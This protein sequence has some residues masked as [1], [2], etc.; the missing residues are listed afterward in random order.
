MLS[1][2]QLKKI[3]ETNRVNLNVNPGI[4]PILLT[5]EGKTIGSLQNFIGITGLPKTGKGKFICGMIASGLS[6]KEVFGMRLKLIEGRPR[7]GFITTD[8]GPHELFNTGQ[9]IKKK[10]GSNFE[11]LDTLNFRRSEPEQIRQAI[12]FYLANEKK[13]SCIFIDNIGDLLF[14]Y[15]DVGQSKKLIHDFKKW[16]TDYNVLIVCILHLGKGNNTSIGHLGAGLDRYAQSVLK[17]EKDKEKKVYTL[18]GEDYLRSAAPFTP[19]DIRY[20]ENENDWIHIWHTDTPKT[21]LKITIPTPAEYDIQYH[22]QTLISIFNSQDVQE[23]K[24]FLNNVQIYYSKTQ[25]WAKECLAHLV[26]S[27]LIAQTDNKYF[28]L[29]PRKKLFAQK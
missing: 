3:L 7:I 26:K 17:V 15:N 1:N 20:D 18:S 2:E 28:L 8:E 6:N 9:L 10:S 27:N 23:Y 24:T 22:R 13:C 19:I 21:D 29:D 11:R 12:P 16:S 5:I 25:K 4:E 14:D